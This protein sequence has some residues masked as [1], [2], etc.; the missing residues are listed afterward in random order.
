MKREF[1]IK[2]INAEL[3][4]LRYRIESLSRS[5][6]HDLNIICEHYIKEI[7][8]IIFDWRLIN[9][10]EKNQNNTAIDLEDV[11]NSIA[12]QVT[13][14]NKKN[15]IQDTLTKFFGNILDQQF[16]IL[17]IFILGKKQRSYNNLIIN[18]G[19]PFDPKINIID[20]GDVINKLHFLPDSKIEKIVQILK[21]DKL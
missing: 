1:L 14:T 3:S 19:F 18:E 8:N 11:A 13:S 20:F 9:S 2:E 4:I 5:N 17:F 21:N 10:N 15:K 7:L 16:T 6:M 12:V